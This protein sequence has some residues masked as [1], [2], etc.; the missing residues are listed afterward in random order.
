M[1]DVWGWWMVVGSVPSSTSPTTPV[2]MF[3]VTPLEGF[4][5]SRRGFVG[6][7]STVT[8]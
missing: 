7:S 3:F 5:R 8:G 6:H 1:L 2:Y 4:R